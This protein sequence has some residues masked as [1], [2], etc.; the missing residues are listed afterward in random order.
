VLYFFYSCLYCMIK[1]NEH[2]GVHVVV[3]VDMHG[4]TEGLRSDFVEAKY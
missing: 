4:S 1:E 3:L 2:F